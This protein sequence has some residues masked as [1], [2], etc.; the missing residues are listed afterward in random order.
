MYQETRKNIKKAQARN[1]CPIQPQ[2]HQNKSRHLDRSS[3][4]KEGIGK[5][6]F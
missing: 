1:A 2:T 3:K 5:N 4:D 6:A